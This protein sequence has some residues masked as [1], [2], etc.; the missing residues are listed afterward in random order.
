MKVFDHRGE[1]N[2]QLIQEQLV[3]IEHVSSSMGQQVAEGNFYIPLPY[4]HELLQQQVT[5][6]QQQL[7][8]VQNSIQGKQGTMSLL[9]LVYQDL[10]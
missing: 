2:F 8:A 10:S 5:S 4:T 9:I 6:M 7:V 1:S 3:D